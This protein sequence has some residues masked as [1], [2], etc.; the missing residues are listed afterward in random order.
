MVAAA[1]GGWSTIGVIF[2]VTNTET[3][4]IFE[5]IFDANMKRNIDMQDLKH[6]ERFGELVIKKLNLIGRKK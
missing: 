5:L 6:V 2:D 1:Y 4:K 3:G